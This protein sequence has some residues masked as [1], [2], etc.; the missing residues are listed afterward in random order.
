MSKI[1]EAADTDLKIIDQLKTRGDLA[2]ILWRE[3]VGIEPTQPDFG[4]LHR[5]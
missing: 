2:L 5:I 1:N 3:G 4:R